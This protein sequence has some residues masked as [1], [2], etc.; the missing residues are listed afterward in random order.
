MGGEETIDKADL[1]GQEQAKTQT[2]QPRGQ[3]HSAVPAGK[4][5]YGKGK[6]HCDHSGDYHHSHDRAYTKEKKIDDGPP[7]I[8]DRR[9]DQQS[10][11]R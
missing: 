9:N 6:G 8:A 7:R 5:T 11:R 3:S 10:H 1:I 2:Q 4:S